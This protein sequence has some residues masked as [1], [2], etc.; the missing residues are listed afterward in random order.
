MAHPEPAARFP[1]GSFPPCLTHT[2]DG[3]FRP[4]GGGLG[5]GFQDAPQS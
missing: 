2:V 4:G 3:I 1:C 5:G